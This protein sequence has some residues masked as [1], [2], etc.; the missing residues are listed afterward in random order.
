MQAMQP[1]VDRAFRHMAQGSQADARTVKA[2]AGC[3]LQ[4]RQFS[5]GSFG[6]RY[7][8]AQDL[9]Q[10]AGWL[11]PCF[12]TSSRLPL[13]LQEHARHAWRGCMCLANSV[14]AQHPLTTVEALQRVSGARSRPQ[15]AGELL[16]TPASNQTTLPCTPVLELH[17]AL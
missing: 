17:H 7:D 12:M 5:Q 14:M 10:A 1:I 15:V 2:V 16:P 9:L 13:E 4:L 8:I 6:A 3:I 11:Y